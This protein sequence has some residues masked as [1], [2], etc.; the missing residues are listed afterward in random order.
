[1]D[2]RQFALLLLIF[3]FVAVFFTVSVLLTQL[4]LRKLRSTKAVKRVKTWL[5]AL[6]I[7]ILVSQI[8]PITI[9]FLTVVSD[10]KRSTSSVNP[11]G[12]VYAFS[13]SFTA[14]ILSVMIWATY[15]TAGRTN[16]RLKKK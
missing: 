6:T 16:V 12:I 1:M 4:K 5:L 8:A 15:K 9:D 3:R 14:M 2:I 7:I 10:L 11:V 13:N